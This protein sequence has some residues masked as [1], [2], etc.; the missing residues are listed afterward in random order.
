M[1]KMISELSINKGSIMEKNKNNIFDLNALTTEEMI[2][3]VIGKNFWQTNDL[4]GKIPTVFVSDGPVGV[5]SSIDRNLQD[6]NKVIPSTSY[7]TTHVLAQTFNKKLA[8][9][10]ARCIADDMI[11]RNLDILLAPGINIKRHPLCGRNFEYLAEDPLL[12]GE[13]AYEYIQGLNEKNVGSCLKHYI[14][15]NYEF[16]RH[17]VSCEIDEQAFYEVYFF[18]FMKALKAKPWSLMCSYNLVGGVRMSENG[19]LYNEAYQNG[20]DGLIMSDWEAVKDATK[21]INAGMSLIMPYQT[22]HEEKLNEDIKTGQLNKEA[23]RLAA[24]RVL[25]F[26]QKN[27]EEKKHRKVETT[28]QERKNF[29]YRVALEGIV[30]LENKN[31]FLPLLNKKTKILVGGVPTLKYFTG[32]G[33]S[34]ITLDHEFKPLIQ[35][36]K[37]L[38]FINVTQ[39]DFMYDN[40]A[41]SVIVGNLNKFVQDCHENDVIILGVGA[42]RDVIAEDFDRQDIK[43]SK[44]ELLGINCV[45]KVGKPVILVVYGGGVFDLHEVKDKVDAIIYAGFAGERVSDAL[46]TLISGKANFSGRLTETFPVTL[47]ESASYNDY[48]DEKVIKYCDGIDVGYKYYLAHNVKTL[49]PFGYGLN[50]SKVEYSNLKVESIT[51]D[52]INFSVQ[53]KNVSDY[54]VDEAVLLFVST[55]NCPI[56]RPVRSLA[57]FAKVNLS[58]NQEKTVDIS[59]LKDDLRYFDVENHQFKLFAGQYEFQICSD[60]E[61]VLLSTIVDLSK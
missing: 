33:S 41:H 16:Q 15:N 19:F 11:E 23:L 29:A 20:F 56:K 57:A 4:N 43:L 21:S 10:Y 38:G 32:G 40:R 60:A 37:D 35:S 61:H 6:T 58:S 1:Y 25:D 17:W 30:L 54:S 36:M 47:E 31:N 53:V 12:S 46:A 49:Y 42:D 9:D 18:N 34:I 28:L 44:E 2:K 13:M 50:Y 48:I 8:K 3:L 7:P 5:R 26:I 22:W 14:C 51:S 27:E 39:G 55:L 45:S 52:K 59:V 24:A